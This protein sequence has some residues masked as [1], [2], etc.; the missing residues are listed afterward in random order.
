[1]M[2]KTKAAMWF[3]TG[4]ALLAGACFLAWGATGTLSLLGSFALVEGLTRYACV[5]RGDDD[6][7]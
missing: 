4:L 2:K 3:Y 6:G 5:S 7:D 1:M